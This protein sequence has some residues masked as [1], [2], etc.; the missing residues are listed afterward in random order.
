MVQE[1][2]RIRDETDYGAW[3]RTAGFAPPEPLV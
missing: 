3:P 1:S 2:P